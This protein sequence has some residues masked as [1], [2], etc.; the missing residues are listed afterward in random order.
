ME[1]IFMNHTA[2]AATDISKI[3]SRNRKEFQVS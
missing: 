1:T 2:A 3:F